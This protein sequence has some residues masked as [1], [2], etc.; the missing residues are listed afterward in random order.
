ME[1]ERI[2]IQTR[3]T[4][5]ARYA[6]AEPGPSDP[7]S[8]RIAHVPLSSVRICEKRRVVPELFLKVP[9]RPADLGIGFVPID[10][11]KV[12]MGLGVRTDL[13]SLTVQL[14]HLI[15][16]QPRRWRGEVAV[17]PCNRVRI[18]VTRDD[19]EC[20]GQS[21][22]LQDRR[23][24]FEVSEVS[25][26]E[27]NRQRTRDRLP[28][29]E[30]TNHVIQCGDVEMRLEKATELLEVVRCSRKAVLGKVI[31][32]AMERHD[33]STVSQRGTMKPRPDKAAT[34]PRFGCMPQRSH[35]VPDSVHVS[36][37]GLSA[38][39]DIATP[40]RSTR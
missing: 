9:P 1:V 28:L 17:P 7:V 13:E 2:V 30:A 12:D 4:A 32:D 8:I 10:Y 23:G 31:G 29:F 35:S 34:N 24:H 33:D 22:L 3:E 36:L 19:E 16:W 5:V 20:R 40:Q 15:P 25:I 14:A 21:E 38:S 26:I 27:R 11:A 6:A 37:F 39:N 18:E